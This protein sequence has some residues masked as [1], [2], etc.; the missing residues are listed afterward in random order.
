[1]TCILLAV[2]ICAFEVWKN[3]DMSSYGSCNLCISSMEQL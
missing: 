2:V 1:M 3:Y